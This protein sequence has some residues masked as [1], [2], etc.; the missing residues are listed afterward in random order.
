MSVDASASIRESREPLS[1]ALLQS[2]LTWPAGLLAQLTVL[3]S[4]AST[5]EDALMLLRTGVQVPHLSAIVADHQTAGKGR[6]GRAWETPAGTSLTFSV[7][8]RPEVARSSFGWVPMIA[9]LAV[10]RALGLVGVSARLKWPNDVVV[11]ADGAA[12]VAGWGNLRKVCGVLCEVEGRAVVIGIG[13]NVSQL[14]DDLPVPHATS[15]AIAGASSL[16]RGALLA[17][18][19]RELEALVAAWERDPESIRELVARACSTIGQSVVVDVPGGDPVTGRVVGLSDGGGLDIDTG[20]ETVTIVA[21][22]VR[23]RGSV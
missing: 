15:L 14:I 20:G 19:V 6:A 4:T 5:N 21:G 3:E 8:V 7:V 9:G 1:D 18:I 2:A 16:D 13:V 17:R 10:V 22:D 12:P 11:P 23:V